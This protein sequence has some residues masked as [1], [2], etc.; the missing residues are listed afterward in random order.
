M[1]KA[2]GGGTRAGKGEYV[3]GRRE[4]AAEG[5]KHLKPKGLSDT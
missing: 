2:P 5:C 4:D 3:Q 1:V